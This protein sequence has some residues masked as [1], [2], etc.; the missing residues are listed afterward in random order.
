M[1]RKTLTILGLS[2]FALTATANEA[3]IQKSLEAKLGIKVESDQG[4]VS[5]FV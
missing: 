1:M 2:L 4:R 5:G 3:E